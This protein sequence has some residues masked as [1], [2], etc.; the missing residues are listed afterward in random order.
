MPTEAPVKETKT[1]PAAK[2]TQA[3]EGNPSVPG[4][5]PTSSGNPLLDLLGGD[6]GLTFKG[7]VITQREIREGIAKA[8]NRPYCIATQKALAGSKTFKIVQISDTSDN[9]PEEI[10]V[11]TPIK[12]LVESADKQNR[13]SDI[14]LSGEILP[15]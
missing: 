11:G 4:Q 5:A 6:A 14:E 9:L 10:A 1:S 13:D 3:G 7:L 12:M 2:R 15:V 8:S